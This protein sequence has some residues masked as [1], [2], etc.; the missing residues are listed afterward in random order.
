[1]PLTSTEEF[2]FLGLGSRWYCSLLN[3]AF[4]FVRPL[5]VGV[6]LELHNQVSKFNS[7]NNQCGEG[8]KEFFLKYFLYR[9]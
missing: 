3:G 1:M 6:H 8:I 7:F 9:R 2:H 4:H 5:P